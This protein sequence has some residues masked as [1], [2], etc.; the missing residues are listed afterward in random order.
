[1]AAH[2]KPAA[3]TRCITTVVMR[4]SGGRCRA[5]TAR[6]QEMRVAVM[7]FPGYLLLASLTILKLHRQFGPDGLHSSAQLSSPPTTSIVNSQQERRRGRVV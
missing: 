4:V 1:M 7:S 2:W 5:F 6:M 3:A